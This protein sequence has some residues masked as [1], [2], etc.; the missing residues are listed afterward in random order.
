MHALEYLSNSE[1]YEPDILV[2][3]QCTSPLTTSID[4]DNVIKKLLAENADSALT[5][6]PFHYYLWKQDDSGEVLGINHDKF[7]RPM[8][9]QREKQYIETGAVYVMRVSQFLKKKYRFFGK[10]VMSEMPEERC[11]E[12]DEPADLAIAE[13]LIL[14][15]EQKSNTR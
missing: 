12:I 3:L 7:H 11:F 8:R 15:K 1:N 14:Y 13:Q 2:F 10:I 4:I 9:Q 5:V 6:A